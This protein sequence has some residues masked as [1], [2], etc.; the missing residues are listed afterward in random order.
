MIATRLYPKVCPCC[1]YM[2]LIN[3]GTFLYCNNCICVW[4]LK[5]PMFTGDNHITAFSS[6][7]VQAREL[8]AFA[9]NSLGVPVSARLLKQV[10]ESMEHI[11]FVTELAEVAPESELK[12]L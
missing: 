9:R 12:K 5:Y 3:T 4:K 8:E 6:A 11:L 7:Y 10:E 2:T 1:S